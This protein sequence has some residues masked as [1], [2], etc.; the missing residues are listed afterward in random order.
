[1]PA[2]AGGFC[3]GEQAPAGTTCQGTGVCDDNGNCILETCGNGVIEPGEQC[4]GLD[5][6]G[7]TCVTQGFAGGT[8]A[9]DGNCQFDVSACLTAICGNGV[10][11]PGETCDDGNQ[12]DGDGC[13]S[14]CQE[15]PGFTCTGSP[16]TCVT[17]CG[18]GIIAGTEDCDGANLN[19]ET[20]V[21]RGYN[22]G[23]LACANDCQS[24]DESG[25][26]F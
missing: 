19:G 25:C 8:L 1:V 15:E 2:C 21:S 6:N 23:T 22:G 20:C 26:T 16:S 9:C 7:E 12:L 24:F 4:D 17:T 18:D 13:S 5:L 11:D 14:T 10:V 3:G